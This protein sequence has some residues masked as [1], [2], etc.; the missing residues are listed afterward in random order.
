MNSPALEVPGNSKGFLSFQSARW[1]V[2][3]AVSVTALALLGVGLASAFGGHG[4][5]SIGIALALVA[6]A[7]FNLWLAFMVW[8]QRTWVS[9]IVITLGLVHLAALISLAADSHWTFALL[10]VVPICQVF[11]SI[12]PS[13]FVQRPD[14]REQ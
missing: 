2:A 8:R 10:T 5:F 14:S 1:I 6:Y 9:G 3:I 11:F 7:L 12:W 13:R 4:I